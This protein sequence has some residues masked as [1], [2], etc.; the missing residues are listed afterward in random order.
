M[1]NGM[2][3][4]TE[5]L[6]DRTIATEV[7]HYRSPKLEYSHTAARGNLTVL[8]IA[9]IVQSVHVS[10]SAGLVEVGVLEFCAGLL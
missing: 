1:G 9:S 7:Y 6:T 4:P 2:L 8:H 3:L 5:F 10:S